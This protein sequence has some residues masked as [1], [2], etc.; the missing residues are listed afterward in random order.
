M[1][2]HLDVQVGGFKA[3]IGLNCAQGNSLTDSRVVDVRA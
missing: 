3:V 2:R 1:D